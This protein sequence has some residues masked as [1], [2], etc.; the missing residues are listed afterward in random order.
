[1]NITVEIPDSAAGD[2]ATAGQDRRA[3]DWE[4]SREGYRADRLSE[5]SVGRLLGFETR[6]EADGF[7]KSTAPFCLTRAAA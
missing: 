7:Q 3:L 6:Y 5:A 2:L 4:P 1:M